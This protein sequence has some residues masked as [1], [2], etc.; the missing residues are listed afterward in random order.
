MKK[1]LIPVILAVLLLLTACA[2]NNSKRG[3]ELGYFNYPGLDW[4]MTEEE[5]FKALNKNE[6]EFER[7]NFENGLSYTLYDI[8]IFNQK[9]VVSFYLEA[10]TE[11]TAPYLTGIT[12]GYEN[13]K[14]F[15]AIHKAL[16]EALDS[17]SVPIDHAEFTFRRID[18][19]GKETYTDTEDE[20]FAENVK[21]A[22]ITCA[23]ASV[24][25]TEELPNN[26]YE[27]AYKGFSNV[28]GQYESL[29]EQKFNGRLSTASF[30]YIENF[31]KAGNVESNNV[32]IRM[33][34]AIPLIDEY[35][36]LA[37]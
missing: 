23:F 8:E 32:I 4:G 3:K 18:Q 19:D 21:R 16:G 33:S 6:T 28:Y 15:S 22:E 29:F 9:G 36:A 26:M 20:L 25:L 12:I 24:A 1:K 14:D 13:V 17:Q 10:D 2:P 5:L 7:K 34:S 30:A 31:D 35:I 37:E 11:E 27:K